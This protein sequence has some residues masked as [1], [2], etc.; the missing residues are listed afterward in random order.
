MQPLSKGQARAPTALYRGPGA[1]W[2]F[3]ALLGTNST[4]QQD[5]NKSRQPDSPEL[6]PA[7]SESV[8]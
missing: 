2:E 7:S 4:L 5:P 1:K 3:S 8:P 6:P